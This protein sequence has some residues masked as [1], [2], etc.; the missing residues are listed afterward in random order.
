MHK[1]PLYDATWVYA[2]LEMA[3]LRR[4]Y[5]ESTNTLTS[6]Q[7]SMTLLAGK[8]QLVQKDIVDR[9]VDAMDLTKP[10]FFVNQELERR[11][12]TTAA[13]MQGLLKRA[14]DLIQDR[15]S[16]FIIDPKDVLLPSLRG[17]SMISELVNAWSI[18]R[19]HLK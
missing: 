12:A 3:D 10:H 11:I 18:L 6:L 5:L 4:M 15:D 14:V 8:T 7:E 16:Y 19:G 1:T 2:L 13:D 17:C 9:G